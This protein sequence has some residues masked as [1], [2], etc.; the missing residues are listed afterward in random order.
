VKVWIDLSNSPH[1]LLFAPIARR[2]EELDHTVF[3]TARDNAQTVELGRGYWPGLEVVGGESPGGRV[4]KARALAARV[5]PLRRIARRERP[6]VA[7]SHNSYAQ[8]VAAKLAGV[9]AVTAMDFEF[10]PANHL[11]FRLADR[12]L[13]P[14]V[15][16]GTVVRTQGASD[17]KTRYYR[18]LKE[19]LY[20]GDFRPNPAV[21][22][23]LGAGDRV[24]VVLR[25]PPSRAIYHRFGNQ[26]FEGVLRIVGS[27]PRALCI[28][29]A[30]HAEQREALAELG[31][32]SV[33]A[34]PSAVDARSLMYAA[35]LVVGAGG[36][37]TREAALLR[38]PTFS[39][40]AGTPPAVDR[41]LEQRGLLRRLERAE[42]VIPLARRAGS[43]ALLA[44][45]RSRS[46]ELSEYL[47]DGVTAGAF[48]E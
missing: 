41:W 23:Q 11:A 25:T 7:L 46:A 1:A 21:R 20:L 48:T 9:R 4:A 45:L 10:Q 15:L 17:R 26:L 22:D 33:V 38:I 34:P 19:E 3:V 47:I 32:P 37:M 36:T 27:D 6:D 29:L 14:E 12:V 18:G 44:E 16:R 24:L 31:L 5:G 35:D 13:L 40:F 42:D 30:R 39:A 2:L 28:V 8:I 43:P